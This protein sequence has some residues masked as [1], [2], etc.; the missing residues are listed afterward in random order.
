MTVEKRELSTMMYAFLVI[1][2][3]IGVALGFSVGYLTNQSQ[4]S[5]LNKKVSNLQTSE[6]SSL[7]SLASNGKPFAVGAAGTLTYAFG[8]E[9]ANFEALYPSI[10]VAP[11][12]FEGSGLV[13]QEENLTQS[14]SLEAAADTTAMPSVLF[15]NLANYEI[16]FGQTQM[17][18]IVNLKLSGGLELYNMWNAAKGLAVNSTAWTTAWKNMFN[19]IAINSTTVVGVSNPFTDPSGFQAA[20]MIR[21]AGLTF[22]GNVTYLYDAIYNNPSKYYMTNSEDDLVPLMQTQH[23]DFITSSYESNAIPQTNSTSTPGLA[24]ITLPT[25]VNLGVLAGTPYYNK[26]NFAYTELGTTEN[27]VVNPVV[28]CVTIP[29]VSTNSAAA[30]LFIQNLYTKTGQSI[31]EQYG[32]TPFSQG[33]VY[34]AASASNVPSVLKPYTTPVNSTDLSQFAGA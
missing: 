19:L 5:S 32:I 24:W 3:L 7:V 23:I 4:I 9:L 34:P 16:A 21:L 8:K 17:V 25:A 30:T 18:I 15:P 2:L 12:L 14:L 1:G 6:T 20:G 29:T 11:P 27:F 28:Y 13:A 26:A 33:I 10:T 22:F 31:L